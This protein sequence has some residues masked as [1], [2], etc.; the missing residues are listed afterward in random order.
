[1]LLSAHGGGR[2][3]VQRTSR[4]GMLAGHRLDEITAQARALVAAGR[5]RELNRWCPDGG[6]SSMSAE[7]AVQKRGYFHPVDD[8]SRHAKR[9]SLVD[10]DVDILRV[11]SALTVPPARRRNGANRLPR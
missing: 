4:A 6:T 11:L 3:G 1:M 8:H 10:D 2:D 5:G 7:I 9:I